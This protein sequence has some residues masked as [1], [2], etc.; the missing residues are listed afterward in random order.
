MPTG[1]DLSDHY[2][3]ASD[4]EDLIKSELKLDV[5]IKK[6]VYFNECDYCHPTICIEG[7]D[8]EITMIPRDYI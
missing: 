1:V 8:V 3:L 4:V 2:I 7:T 5:V 6:G